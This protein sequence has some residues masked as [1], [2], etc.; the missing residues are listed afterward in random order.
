MD[1]RYAVT[2]TLHTHC[3]PVC[4]W[5]VTEDQVVPFGRSRAIST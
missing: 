3:K 4:N 2:C 1:W 5:P